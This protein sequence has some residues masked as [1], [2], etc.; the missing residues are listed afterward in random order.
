MQSPCECCIYKIEHREGSRIFT[1]CQ[2]DAKKSGFVYDDFFYRHK[3]ANHT[4]H[5]KCLTCKKY[6][7]PYCNN[8]YVN[9]EYVPIN[10]EA[11]R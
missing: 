2:D 1:S 8:V 6:Q 3:C 7:K 10:E 5:E 11:I 9:C 4:P